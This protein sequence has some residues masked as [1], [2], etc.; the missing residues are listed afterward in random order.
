MN[1]TLVFAESNL[2]TSARDLADGPF[3]GMQA[4]TWAITGLSA[5]ATMLIAT[6]SV[7]RANRL[8][9]PQL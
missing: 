7:R 8:A 4:I 6:R 9:T 2:T 1:S 5:V 3:W